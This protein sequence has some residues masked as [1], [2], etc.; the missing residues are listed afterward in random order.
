MTAFAPTDDQRKTVVTAIAA[1]LGVDRV[2]RDLGISADVFMTAFAAE[3]SSARNYI[4]LGNLEV[5]IVIRDKGK[6][7]NPAVALRAIA[8]IETLLAKAEAREGDLPRTAAVKAV[9]LGKKDEA[10]LRARNAFKGNSYEKF[11]G[12]QR[13]N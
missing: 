8:L 9:K 12:G 1:G 13:A 10:D 3:I 5:A 11:L 2:A 7:F 4:R 6:R